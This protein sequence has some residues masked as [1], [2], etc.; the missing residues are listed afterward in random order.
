MSKQVWTKEM[1]KKKIKE[2]T[3]KSVNVNLFGE[4]E[5]SSKE[6]KNE[7]LEMLG[8]YDELIELVKEDRAIFLPF[9][10]PSLKNSKQIL[11]I[12]TGKSS[13]CNAIYK[14]LGKGHYICTKCNNRCQLGKRPIIAKSKTVEKFMNNASPILLQYKK[15]FFDLI[16][17]LPKPLHIGFYFIRGSKHDFDLDNAITTMLDTMK[18][19]EYIYD[20]NSKEIYSYPIGEH[21]NKENQGVIIVPLQSSP[22]FKF[23]EKPKINLI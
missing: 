6:L 14:K 20:D 13:C 22:V 2:G 9:H 21:Y 4:E 8:I 19:V 17:N 1:L 18:N 15:E 3:I 5:V 16:T 12:Y 10:V 7:S 23:I 11:Q